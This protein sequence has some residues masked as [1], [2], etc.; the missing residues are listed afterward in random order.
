MPSLSGR[1]SKTFNSLIPP[2]P[3]S[4]VVSFCLLSTVLNVD[5]PHFVDR[6][7]LCSYILS[8]YLF[9]SLYLWHFFTFD[10]CSRSSD[11]THIPMGAD[12]PSARVFYPLLVR[13]VRTIPPTVFV[14]KNC[15][16]RTY[17]GVRFMYRKLEASELNTQTRISP[18]RLYGCKVR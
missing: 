18:W 4:I 2:W 16:C 11:S 12:P 7:S 5:D 8:S 10:V 3:I 6:L 9:F 1:R 13:I 17:P 15:N 14:S